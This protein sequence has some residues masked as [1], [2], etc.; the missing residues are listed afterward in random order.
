M[1]ILGLAGMLFCMAALA[2]AS[3]TKPVD[4]RDLM[5]V[6]QF[7]QAGLN[8]LTPAELITLN[9]WLN[10]YLDSH[11]V[12]ATA[13]AT[14]PAPAPVPT[15]VPEL[16]PNP[17][18]QAG[19]TVS[20]PDKSVQPAA[21]PSSTA[22]TPGIASFGAETMPPKESPQELNRIESRI[23]GP[24]TGW[25]GDTVFKLENGQVW[26]QAATGYYTDVNLDHPQVVIKKLSFG[27]LL[28][29]PGHG[30]TVFVRRIK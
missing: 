10:Q 9:A 1:R 13:T 8:K 23:A 17:T 11:S 29:M 16:M 18:P 4:I 5:N 20:A 30:Q 19:R 14:V 22:E 12:K 15:S 2:G 26:Q 3:A 27:Y 6:T 25:T 7:D 24:F 21:A 28:T